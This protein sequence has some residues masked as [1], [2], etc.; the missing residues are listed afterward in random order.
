MAVC[1]WCDKRGIFLSVDRNGLCGNC[2]RHIVEIAS[3]IRVMEDSMRLAREGK[4]FSTRV[5]RCELVIEHAT[6]LER[7]ERKGVATV[8]PAPSVLLKEFNELRVGLIVEEANTATEGACQKAEVA[9]TPK[10]KERALVVGLLK[11]LELAKLAEDHPRVRRAEQ[12][13]RSGIHRVTLDG[14]LDAARKAEFKG[15]T[16][17]AIDQYQEALYFIQNDDIDDATQSRE[18]R[19]IQAKLEELGA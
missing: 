16:K 15:N 14:Y 4:T 12:Q 19:E 6:F 8:Q 18:I 17:K 5:S 13:L 2:Q 1:K 11:V 3:R 7:F 10:A 9:T